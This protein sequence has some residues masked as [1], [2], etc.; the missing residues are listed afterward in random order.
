[1]DD[2]FDPDEQPTG[3]LCLACGGDFRGIHETPTGYRMLPCRWCTRG[4]MSPT[5]ELAWKNRED[6]GKDPKPRR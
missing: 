4:A 3:T 6:S 2:T 1:M 5:Q